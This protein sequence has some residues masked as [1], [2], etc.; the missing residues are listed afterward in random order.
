MLEEVVNICDS[1]G[2]VYY[3][4]GGTA[5]GA[6]R[7]RGFI[8]WDDDIDLMMP[9][10]DWERFVEIARNG[11]LPANRILSCHELNIEYPHVFG[12][13]T[14]VTSCAIHYNQMLGGTPEGFIIDIFVLDP[15]P[16]AHDAYQ[17]HRETLSLYNDLSNPY[18]YSYPM[19]A[20]KKKLE[21]YAR[22]VKAE[23][24]DKVLSELAGEL[25]RY[26]PEDCDY[27]VM[28]W[29]A[30]PRLFRKELFAAERYEEFEGLK[31]RVPGKCAD[32]L[33]QHYGDDWMFTIHVQKV[34]EEIHA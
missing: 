19:S 29:A 21:R 7:H 14:D 27:L 4:A 1:N 17:E 3:L 22:R 16:D 26:N 23:G 13:Y 25:E 20:D 5:L 33:V 6:I 18:G 12:R 32:Y 8:P 28:R 34:E 11:G 24:R 30:A 31:V 9:R 15:V 10:A 2:I